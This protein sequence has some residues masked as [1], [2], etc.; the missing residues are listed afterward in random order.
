MALKMKHRLEI[1]SITTD[2]LVNKDCFE[3][4]K[5]DIIMSLEQTSNEFTERF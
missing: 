3:N 1:G 4:E 2:V 5:I